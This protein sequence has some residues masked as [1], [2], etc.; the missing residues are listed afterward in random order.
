MISEPTNSLEKERTREERERERERES[1]FAG[2][3][4]TTYRGHD[5]EDTLPVWNF[6]EKNVG[7]FIKILKILKIKK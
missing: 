2:G 4:G 6:L 7:L 3:E 5:V 1:D